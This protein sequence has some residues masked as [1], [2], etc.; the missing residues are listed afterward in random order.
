MN[1]SLECPHHAT[2]QY[3]IMR[4]VVMALA[5]WDSMLLQAGM[6]EFFWTDRVVKVAL[7]AALPCG[8]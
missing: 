7:G 6:A 1:G 8:W 5:E 2:A 3:F 4:A